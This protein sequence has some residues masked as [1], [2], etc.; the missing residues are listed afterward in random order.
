M[1]LARNFRVYVYTQVVPRTPSSFNWRVPFKSWGA[2]AGAGAERTY[3]AAQGMG[4]SAGRGGHR[5]QGSESLGSGARPLRKY[6]CDAIA[7]RQTVH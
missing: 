2:S 6:A 3:G 1:A 5:E 7:K 4:R